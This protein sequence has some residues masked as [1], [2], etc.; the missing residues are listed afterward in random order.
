LLY[1]IGFG[2]SFFTPK[3]RSHA[4]AYR[5]QIHLY[6]EEVS[7]SR[8]GR[9]VPQK[10]QRALMIKPSEQIIGCALKIHRALGPGL[11]ESVYCKCLVYE[12]EKLGF[13]CQTEVILPVF[14]ET[15]SFET[16]FR[17]DI[18]VNGSTILEIKSTDKT[19]PAHTAQTLTYLKLSKLPLA[20]LINFGEA[21]LVA[22]IKRFANGPE[23]DN[24]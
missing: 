23:G 9:K 13:K 18:I 7:R 5:H 8:E 22:G 16:G 19:S 4:Q 3:D 11:L 12:L 20:L 21:T 24:L 1:T 14:Y 15:L 6:F 17:A 2:T 10:T